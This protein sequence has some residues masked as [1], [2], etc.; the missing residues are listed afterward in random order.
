MIFQDPFASLNPRRTIGDTLEE[1]ASMRGLPGHASHA[2]ASQ[3]LADVGLSQRAA[4]LYPHQFSGG[5]QQRIAIARALAV[6]PHTVICDE[7][8]SALDVSVQASLLNLLKELQRERNLSYLFI[9]HDLGVVRYMSDTV[10]VMHLGRVVESAAARDVFA[11]TAHPYTRALLDSIPRLSRPA[12]AEP[13]HGDPPD[14]RRPPTGCRFHTR[15]PIGPTKMPDRMICVE[16]D[17][18]HIA[19]TRKNNAA[20]HF[21]KAC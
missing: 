5:Q 20:C 1:A 8:T 4:G 11:A 12:T 19:L 21:A 14:P 13:L 16:Q 15:C 7:V 17:P 10:A 2:V 18:Q 9:S 3:V 6:G